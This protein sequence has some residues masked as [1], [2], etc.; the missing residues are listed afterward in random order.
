MNNLGDGIDADGPILSLFSW[1]HGEMLETTFIISHRGIGNKKRSVVYFR[2]KHWPLIAELMFC[3]HANN[4]QINAFVYCTV[5]K[6]SSQ[7]V[8]NLLSILPT[9]HL[10][11]K[12]QQ[13][14]PVTIHQD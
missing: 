1:I 14:H 10:M 5:V 3:C 4:M 6:G 13:E 9:V 7:I 2:G 8:H 12:T 11:L